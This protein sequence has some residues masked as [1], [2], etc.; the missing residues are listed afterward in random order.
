[1]AALQQD[2]VS[3]ALHKEKQQDDSSF[4]DFS[5]AAKRSHQCSIVEILFSFIM[6]SILVCVGLAQ[7]RLQNQCQETQMELQTLK[8]EMELMK[9]RFWYKRVNDFAY[10]LFWYSG[11]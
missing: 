9:V 6:I 11:S 8:S 4:G 10:K 3:L 1:M 2:S 7:Y 5:P